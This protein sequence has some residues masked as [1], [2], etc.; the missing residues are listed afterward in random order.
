LEQQLQLVLTQNCC[1]KPKSVK[2][3]PNNHTC[4]VS[5]SSDSFQHQ[6]AQVTKVAKLMAQWYLRVQVYGQR[7]PNFVSS[8]CI[9]SSLMGIMRRMEK[10]GANCTIFKIREVSTGQL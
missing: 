6:I 4:S 5:V 9:N 7:F 10:T 1:H 8:T 2:R 3:K